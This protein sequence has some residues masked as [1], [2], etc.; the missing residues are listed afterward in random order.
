MRQ[1][2]RSPPPRRLRRCRTAA[3]RRQHNTAKMSP[4]RIQQCS[5]FLPPVA[6]TEDGARRRYIC[7]RARAM[8]DVY[9]PLAARASHTARYT[10]HCCWRA[11]RSSARAAKKRG[12]M[13]FRRVDVRRQ[14]CCALRVRPLRVMRFVRHVLPCH[15]PYAAAA[16]HTARAPRALRR[17]PFCA[18]LRYYIYN[19]YEVPSREVLLGQ[20]L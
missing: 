12:A 13:A 18:P 16:C 2:R 5:S 1:R 10:P 3:A 14:K 19:G 9:A 20:F 11:V 4:T 6:G 15:T 7:R 8:R 17:R